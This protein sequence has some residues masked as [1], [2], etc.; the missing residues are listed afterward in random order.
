[1]KL[2]KGLIKRVL[3]NL[4][5]K[6]SRIKKE[7]WGVDLFIDISR[8]I[9]LNDIKVVFDVGANIGQSRNVYL[10]KFPSSKIFS[11]EPIKS[12]FKTLKESNPDVDKAF[13][14]NLALGETNEKI[15]IPLQEKSTQNSLSKRRNENSNPL[16]NLE[17]V[18]VDTLDN[19]V[20]KIDIDNIDFLKIDTEGFEMEVL[21]G[22]SN[23][24]KSKKVRFILLELGI[25]SH[26]RTTFYNS[27]QEYLS[28]F[29]YDVIGFYK[30]SQ[31]LYTKGRFLMHC[32]VL[33][34]S[35]EW[36]KTLRPKFVKSFEYE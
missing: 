22:A 33:F 8:L 27:I 1:M 9:D 21:K 30:Q 26:P 12:T 23:F 28:H 4:G 36:S 35:S 32:D 10:K 19:I 3:S 15:K 24:L 25:K 31:S 5:L 14:F 18:Q 20:E 11:F 16:L 13:S 6:V 34:I 17:E 29:G 2:I 7:H